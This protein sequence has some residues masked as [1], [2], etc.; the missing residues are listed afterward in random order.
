MFVPKEVL[1]KPGKLNDEEWRQM[2]QHPAAGAKYPSALSD[3]PKLAMIAAFEHRMKF[4][5]NDTPA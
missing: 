4:D 5:G 3:V 1:E 2:K